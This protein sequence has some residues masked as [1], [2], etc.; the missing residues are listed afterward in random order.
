MNLQALLALLGDLYAQ[1]R[2][3]QAENA[4]LKAMLAEQIPETDE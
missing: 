4:A 2:E 1:L 3:L